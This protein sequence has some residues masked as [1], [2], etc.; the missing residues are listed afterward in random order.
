MR[1]LYAF[2]IALMC[3]FATACDPGLGPTALPTEAPT[4]ADGW[5]GGWDDDDDDDDRDRDDAPGWRALRALARFEQ[6]P[7]TPERAL[8]MIGPEGGSLSLG[9][10]EIVVPPG[11]VT[12]HTLFLIRRPMDRFTR[13]FVVAELRPH[14]VDFA[15]PVLVRFP[16]GQTT[17]E[18]DP[19]AQVARW[20]GDDDGWS[21]HPSMIIEGGARMEAAVTHFSYWGIYTGELSSGG[22]IRMERPVRPE[23]KP[24]SRPQRYR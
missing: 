13:Q 8:A 15:V 19:D 4:A 24:F 5:K 11:A 22:D 23:E 12:H 6:A 3:A 14:H 20:Q 17:G 21:L 10:F 18:N 2:V 7:A 9:A 1:C 16:L